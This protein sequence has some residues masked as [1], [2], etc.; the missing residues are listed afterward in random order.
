MKNWK[1]NNNMTKDQIF[2]LEKMTRGQTFGLVK[3]EIFRKRTLTRGTFLWFNKNDD[4]TIRSISYEVGPMHASMSV[5]DFF[6]K[7]KIKVLEFE[8]PDDNFSD[9]EPKKADIVKATN[10]G[11][12]ETEYYPGGFPS[13]SYLVYGRNTRKVD[14]AVK[15][16]RTRKHA[17]VMAKAIKSVFGTSD[18]SSPFKM[19]M[20]HAQKMCVTETEFKSIMDYD[21]DN[22]IN[23]NLSIV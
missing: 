3:P 16:I 4:G 11:K 1:N 17:I 13:R 23:H 18:Y 9:L 6:T 5:D 15:R 10:L 7:T 12:M 21:A 2:T 8:G 19:F 20:E 22:R 14:S